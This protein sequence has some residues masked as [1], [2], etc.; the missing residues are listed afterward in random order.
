MSNLND[1][2]TKNGQRS[3][4]ILPTTVE[5]ETDARLLLVV[6]LLLGCG[7]SITHQSVR[8]RELIMVGAEGDGP[9]FCR[10]TAGAFG[11]GL[12]YTSIHFVLSYPCHT[13]ITATLL[14]PRT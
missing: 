5:N 8:E 2:W 9:M 3:D 7:I 1:V 12:R 6:G 14:A 4:D 10:Y 13:F 11:L